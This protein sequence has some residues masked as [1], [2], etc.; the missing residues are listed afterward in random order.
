MKDRSRAVLDKIEKCKLTV[1]K[2][3]DMPVKEVGH[4]INDLKQ[5][6][7][8]KKMA[9]KIPK[10]SISAQ[11]Q[12]ITRTIVRIVVQANIEMYWSD[13]AEFIINIEF[14]TKFVIF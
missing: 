7:F 8:V 13:K 11:V 5:A 10:I 14:L 4:M 2:I 12:P 9:E 3:R 6:E 1:E